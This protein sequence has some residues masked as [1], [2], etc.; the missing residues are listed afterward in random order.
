[1]L[2]CF[3]PLYSW[4][5]MIKM[6][7]QVQYVH[8]MTDK[9]LWGWIMHAEKRLESKKTTYLVDKLISQFLV[10]SKDVFPYLFILSINVKFKN[11]A[12]FRIF[13]IHTRWGITL[14]SQII[15]PMFFLKWQGLT[16]KGGT[17][18]SPQRD[19]NYN[20]ITYTSILKHFQ[21]EVIMVYIF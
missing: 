10:L 2:W 4:D 11:C 8:S 18:R 15:G 13:F 20:D 6:V 19:L 3:T 14:S 9:Q 12:L 16:K 17:V 1:M 5:T 7:Y 21:I